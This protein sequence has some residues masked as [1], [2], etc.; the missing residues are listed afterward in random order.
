MIITTTTT[1]S[2]TIVIIMA[3][4]NGDRN[5]NTIVDVIMTYGASRGCTRLTARQYEHDHPNQ[6]HPNPSTVIPLVNRARSGDLKRK[7]SKRDRDE[8][9]LTVTVLGMVAMNSHVSQREIT[10]E[11]NISRWKFGQISKKFHIHS[12]HISLHQKLTD[13][14]KVAR[15]AFCRWAQDQLGCDPMF[16]NRIICSDE[17][18]FQNTGEL[19][20]HNCH[21]YSDVNSH[22]V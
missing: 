11:I 15:V 1:T 17:A 20:R 19:D 22:W 13:D 3:D 4:N 7:R 8:D 5:S 14:D 10:R 9:P 16:C 6:R 21:Y 12:Y 2:T 18:T